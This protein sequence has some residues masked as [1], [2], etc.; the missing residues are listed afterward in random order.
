MSRVACLCCCG[1]RPQLLDLC[2]KY[3]LRSHVDIKDEVK[4][5]LI[6]DGIKPYHTTEFGPDIQYCRRVPDGKNSL[7][8]Q[9][10]FG[11]KLCETFDKIIIW[12]EDDFYSPFRLPIQINEL[13]EVEMH[14]YGLTRYYS[15]K[16]FGLQQHLNREHSSFFETG[17]RSALIPTL[18]R[19]IKQDIE[20]PY[21]DML[22]WK[23]KNI[24]KKL[25]IPGI[26]GLGM[27]GGPG[28][29]GYTEAHREDR[30]AFK[31][32][33]LEHFIGE[34]AKAYREIMANA[35]S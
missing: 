13:D 17:F 15:L 28:R 30:R 2:I 24:K 18:V 27:K 19:L 8:R 16:H 33:P 26:H 23:E 31:P 20:F 6:D 5:F 9:M 10:L 12:E 11:L 22:I 3:F 14:G 34:D 1:D 29:M 7:G 21:Y 4:L 35:Q 32:M 25:T